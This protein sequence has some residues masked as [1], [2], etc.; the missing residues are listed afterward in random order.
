MKIANIVSK[1]KI[2]VSDEFNVVKTMDEINHSLPT[3][4]VG[5]DYVKKTFPDFDITNIQLKENVYWTFKKT[6]KRDKFEEDM[7][8]FIYKAY[9]ELVKNISYIFVDPIQ[10]DNKTLIKIT[11]KILSMKNIITYVNNEMM[12]VFGEKYIFGIDLKLLKYIGLNVD[13]IKN[14]FEKVSSVFLVDSKILIE[15]KNSVEILG[16][17]VRYIPY[18]YSLTHGQNN[19]SSVIHISRKGIVVP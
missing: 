19:T 2:S 16:N 14:K 18:L 9:H 8:W 17:K 10:Y 4:V 1:D 5:Y 6:E 11:R 7:N 3:L 15:Y 13:K 12:Y